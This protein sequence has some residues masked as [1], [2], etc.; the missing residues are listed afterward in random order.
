MSNLHVFALVAVLALGGMFAVSAT[1]DDAAVDRDDVDVE[2][3][4]SHGEW[5]DLPGTDIEDEEFELDESTLD[6]GTDYELDRD[7][8][9]ILFLEDG[10]TEETDTVDG[11]YSAEVPAELA[12]SWVG[13]LGPVLSLI[14]VFAL[15]LAAAAVLALLLD[16]NRRIGGG[17]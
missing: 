9:Q 4:V 16:A 13:T 6:E 12:E 2:I 5:I 10:A 17:Y 14:G 11:S 8:G 3:S 15:A 1:Y 7:A